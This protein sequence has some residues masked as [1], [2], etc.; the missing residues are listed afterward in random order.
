MST[1]ASEPSEP[2]VP[3]EPEE[4]SE[5][6]SEMDCGLSGS[7]RLAAGRLRLGER[8]SDEEEEMYV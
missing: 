3:S 1:V 5:C 4:E 2:A 6:E 7:D 8:L